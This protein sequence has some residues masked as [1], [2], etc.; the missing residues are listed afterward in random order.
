M[1]DKEKKIA[2]IMRTIEIEEQDNGDDFATNNDDVRF[3]ISEINRLQKSLKETEETA[4]KWVKAFDNADRNY[5]KKEKLAAERLREID[6]LQQ[7]N[8][9]F[10]EANNKLQSRLN[11]QNEKMSELQQENQRLKEDKRKL[12]N[13][14]ESQ[15]EKAIHAQQERDKALEALKFYAEKGHLVFCQ[16]DGGFARSFLSDLGKPILSCLICGDKY[17][18]GSMHYDDT[19]DSCAR[20]NGIL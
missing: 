10:Y 14:Y 2:E 4:S 17:K 7:E 15:F 8:D 9:H 3:L 20:K 5:L 11:V 12:H 1:T 6:R 13:A 19:C 18:S 16:E